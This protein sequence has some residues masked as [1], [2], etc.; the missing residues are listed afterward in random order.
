VGGVI[1][2]IG[3]LT[4]V[5]PVLYLEVLFFPW[6]LFILGPSL[7]FASLLVLGALVAFS[8]TRHIV[9]GLHDGGWIP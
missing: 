6:F 3:G 9:K 2:L 8:K 1:L 7:A 4:A 5:I